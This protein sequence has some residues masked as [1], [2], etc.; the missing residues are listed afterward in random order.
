M[1]FIFLALAKQNYEMFMVTLISIWRI[2]S[3]IGKTDLCQ[4]KDGTKAS[5]CIIVL[6]KNDMKVQR[7]CDSET[8]E[9]YVCGLRYFKGIQRAFC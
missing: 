1:T 5:T 4:M 7:Q 6:Y 8:D 9:T 2:F 3:F